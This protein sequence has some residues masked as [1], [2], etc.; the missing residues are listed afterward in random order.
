L[1]MTSRSLQ[2]S[3]APARAPHFLCAAKKISRSAPRPRSLRLCSGPAGQAG[4]SG[5]QGA[6][7]S[8]FWFVFFGRAKKMNN[9]N[10]EFQKTAESIMVVISG[11]R[12]YRFRGNLSGAA[13]CRWS[14]AAASAPG[15][16]GSRP[17]FGTA[18]RPP[19]TTNLIEMQ[20]LPA[21]RKP[22]G[23]DDQDRGSRSIADRL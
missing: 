15:C 17:R 5:A 9:K 19:H 12:H 6:L 8:F 22:S 18:N 2:L 23:F 4:R 1:L 11:T 21:E 10:K 20:T 14:I 13:G 16:G 7:V 3:F